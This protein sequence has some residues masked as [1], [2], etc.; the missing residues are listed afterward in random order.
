MTEYYLDEIG[1]AQQ[2]APPGECSCSVVNWL[3][4]ALNCVIDLRLTIKAVWLQ[5]CV[6]VPR[7]MQ[8]K[9]TCWGNVRMIA[10]ER[11]CISCRQSSNAI[12]QHNEQVLP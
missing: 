3:P 10:A 1:S 5:A 8:A 9:L 6:M 7:D 4:L 2:S 11:L 12:S